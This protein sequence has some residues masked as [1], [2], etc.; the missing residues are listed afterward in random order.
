MPWSNL[1]CTVRQALSARWDGAVTSTVRVAEALENMRSPVSLL[2]VQKCGASIPF[3]W[4]ILRGFAQGNVWDGGA[5]RYAG[6]GR[7]DAHNAI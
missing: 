3:T 4:S 7:S 2:I 1:E 5:S 6:N